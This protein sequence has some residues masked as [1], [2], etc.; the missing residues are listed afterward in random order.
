MPRFAYQSLG[1]GF[2]GLAVI[3][4]I[5]PLL[6]STPFLLLAAGCFARSSPQ[7]NEWLFRSPL[8]GPILREWHSQGRVSPMTKILAIGVMCAAGSVTLLSGG[9]SWTINACLV[10]A[11]TLGAGIVLALPQLEME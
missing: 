10:V 11:M 3:G 6:P 4:A 1:I 5:L 8:F 9:F 2:V 7:W